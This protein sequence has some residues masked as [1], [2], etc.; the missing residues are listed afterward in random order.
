MQKSAAEREEEIC[1]RIVNGIVR[2][3]QEDRNRRSQ[4]DFI[5]ARPHEPRFGQPALQAAAA[6]VP[7]EDICDHWAA[8]EMLRN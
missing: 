3:M 6:Y 2:V 8:G 4:S 7:T 1:L 5:E